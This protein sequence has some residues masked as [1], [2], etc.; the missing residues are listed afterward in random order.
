LHGPVY[1]HGIE[2]AHGP[3]WRKIAREIGVKRPAS[4][5]EAKV[6]EC[7]YFATCPTCGKTVAE[8]HLIIRKMR[9]ATS[10][11]HHATVVWHDRQ[12]GAVKPLPTAGLRP[13][14]RDLDV[15]D[16]TYAE[17]SPGRKAAY[18][19]RMRAIDPQ[20]KP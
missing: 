7:R 3:R 5:Q 1:R 8:R 2:K 17:M 15:I 16:L 6:V 11:C 9:N 4:T 14:M 12:T 20:W 19:K 18:T 10:R 13:A